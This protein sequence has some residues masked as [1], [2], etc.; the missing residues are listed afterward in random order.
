VAAAVGK[1]TKAR[2]PYKKGGDK[3]MAYLMAAIESILEKGL[4]KAAKSKKQKSFLMT[5]PLVIPILNRKLG[6]VTW[7]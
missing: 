4:K 7:S 5:R 6:A 1:P 2:K 3:Q